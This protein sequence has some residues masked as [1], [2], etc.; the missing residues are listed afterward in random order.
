MN[1]LTYIL[2][3]ESEKGILQSICDYCEKNDFSMS[4]ILH[5]KD[6]DKDGVLKKAHWHIVTNIPNKTLRALGCTRKI[7]GVQSEKGMKDYLIH[8]N[9]P[10]KYPYSPDSVVNVGEEELFENRPSD[11]EKKAHFRHMV[12]DYIKEHKIREF[13]DIPVEWT[14]DEEFDCYFIKTYID[15]LR[16]SAD[17]DKSYSKRTPTD[18]CDRVV[19]IEDEIPIEDLYEEEKNKNTVLEA[20]Q[21]EL[22]N[23]LKK[24][25]RYITSVRDAYMSGKI[26]ALDALLSE[27]IQF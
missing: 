16:Y 18:E 23:K 12:Y 5:D 25:Q 6:C 8:A 11:K 19:P 20:N 24:Y 3:P 21:Y 9:S 2:Y 10:E 26:D 22:A 14:D 1:L 27:P 15:S 4:Y 17:R 13:K 7:Q